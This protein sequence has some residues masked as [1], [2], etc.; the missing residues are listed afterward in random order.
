MRLDQL[1]PCDRFILRLYNGYEDEPVET[2]TGVFKC[3]YSSNPD[4][5]VVVFDGIEG[6][7]Y[8]HSHYDV[9][10]IEG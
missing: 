9:E 3:V 10:K 1:T 4:F 8:E 5:C 6:E 7:Q 2:R